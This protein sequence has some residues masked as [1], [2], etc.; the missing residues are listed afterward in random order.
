M[1]PRQEI[2]KWSTVCITFLRSGWS[3][4]R[5]ASFAMGGTSKETVTAAPQSFDLE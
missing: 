3:V 5:S 2:S 1:A 4:V